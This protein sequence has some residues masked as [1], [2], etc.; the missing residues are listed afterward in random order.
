[1]P[2]GT[3]PE[4]EFPLRRRENPQ[5]P[6]NWRVE[7]M[8]LSTWW[9]DGEINRAFQKEAQIMKERGKKVLALIPLNL[10]GF[11]FGADYPSD[12]E[13]EI[14]SRVAANFVGWEK[15]P[16]LFDRELEKV[17]RALRT[18]EGGREKPPPAKL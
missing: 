11:L 14:T 3:F 4:P 5:S 15:D 16:A 17:I 7:R 8:R 6:L 13:A 2:E 18:G 10:D 12:K 9:V 1:M